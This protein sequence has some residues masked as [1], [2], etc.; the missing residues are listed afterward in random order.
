MYLYGRKTV[1]CREQPRPN[2]PEQTREE[3]I[4]RKLTTWL[5]FLNLTVHP[6]LS[7]ALNAPVEATN[8]MSFLF[9]SEVDFCQ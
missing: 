6:R 7:P 3:Q 8:K 4:L 9:L 2:T 5:S 1:T